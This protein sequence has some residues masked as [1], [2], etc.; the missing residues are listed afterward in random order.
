VFIASRETIN[1]RDLLRIAANQRRA[2]TPG[3]PL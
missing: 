3:E 2:Q 1:K